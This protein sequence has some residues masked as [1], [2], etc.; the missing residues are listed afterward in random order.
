[1]VDVPGGRPGAWVAVG[2]IGLVGAG[3]LAVGVTTPEQRTVGLVVGAFLLVVAVSMAVGAGRRAG[4]GWTPST[5]DGRPAWA[6]A[7]GGSG[8]AAAMAA[9][10]GVLGVGLVV[11]ALQAEPVVAVLL[12]LVALFLLVL[13]VEGVRLLVRRPE[14]R[15][16]ADRLSLR[17]P[18]V[19]AE[20][21][22]DEVGTV[23]HRDLGTRWAAVAVSAVQGARS[24]RC[25]SRRFLLPTDRVP[26]PPG[27]VVRVGLVPDPTRLVRILRAL[28]AGGRA[29]REAMIGRGLPEA[30]GH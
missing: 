27:I 15:V 24:Y 10:P 21:V 30:S 28:H 11:V 14:L 22:W 4:P 6:L 7:L 3:A 18:G 29:E 9:I 19:D 13:A 1:M 26:D 8:S 23:E 5:L 16:S 12:G 17:G 25:E 2:I 20:L